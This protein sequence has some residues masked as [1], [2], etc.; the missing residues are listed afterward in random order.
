[1]TNRAT[2]TFDV[3]VQPLTAYDVSE[4]TM[5]G[6]MS[7]DKEFQGD[8]VATSKGEMLIG[9]TATKSSAG[10]V[11]IETVNG[12]LHGRQG[13]FLLQHTG[14]MNRGTPSLAITVVP[15]SGTGELVGLSGTM[16]IDVAA[17]GAHSYTFE[18]SIANA[19]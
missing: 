11:A 19:S 1:M 13:T 2:G 3:R 18:Y 9:G 4:G 7:L 17:D 14:T 10:Y 8:L 6:R 5:A 16:S 12:A 15:D